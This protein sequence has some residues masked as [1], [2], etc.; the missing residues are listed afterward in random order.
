[1]GSSQDSTKQEA[2]DRTSNDNQSTVIAPTI[3]LPKGGGAIRGVGENFAANSVTDTGSMLIPIVTS[4]GRSGFG[5][6]LSFS[7]HSSA[8]N[9]PFGF[10]WNLS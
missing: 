8:S 2:A 3:T 4:P 6:Q 9:G 5:P 7:Y 1:M 10:G